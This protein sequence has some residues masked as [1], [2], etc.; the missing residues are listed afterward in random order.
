MTPS[1]LTSTTIGDLVN[2][3]LLNLLTQEQIDRITGELGDIQKILIQNVKEVDEIDLPQDH[4]T[5]LKIYTYEGEDGLVTRS[6]YGSN[7]SV[8]RSP[9]P[10]LKD[11]IKDFE[12]IG[13]AVFIQYIEE[14]KPHEALL[15]IKFKKKGV[16]VCSMKW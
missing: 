10:L 7:P 11:I 3:A 14:G 8:Y 15:C 1:N 4:I 13:A 16:P 12:T 6:W 2:I 9:L 5:S